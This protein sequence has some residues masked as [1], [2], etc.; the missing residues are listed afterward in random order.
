MLIVICIFFMGIKFREDF[1]PSKVPYR[2]PYRT[3]PVRDN[4][5]HT[6]YAI[7]YSLEAARNLV[8]RGFS[9]ALE[10]VPPLKLGKSALGTRLEAARNLVPKAPVPGLK[11]PGDEVGLHGPHQSKY[12]K[13]GRPRIQRYVRQLIWAPDV[14]D[15]GQ[16]KKSKLT[17][18]H[19][20]LMLASLFGAS[21]WSEF[22]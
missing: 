8:P 1:L 18:L 16:T 20:F 7:A 12:I 14:N 9:L 5:N 4:N 10:M 6:P 15:F 17:W 11:R 13:T 3:M 19:F 2:P 21:E 22:L